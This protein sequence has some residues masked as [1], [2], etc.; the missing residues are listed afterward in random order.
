MEIDARTAE[1]QGWPFQQ[2]DLLAGMRRYFDDPTIRLVAVQPV[3][4]RAIRP[5]IG[6]IR[7]LRVLVEGQNGLKDLDLIVKEPRGTTRT[8]LAGAGRREVG[9]YQRLADH[10]PMVTPR[11]IAASQTGDWLL[12]EM[13]LSYK[14]PSRWVQAD[15]LRAIEALGELHDRFWDLDEDLNAFPWLSHPLDA[16]FD[17]H[18][19]AA[20]QAL[21]TIVHRGAPRSLAGSQQH[22]RLM[23]RMIENADLIADP[24][25]NETY[26]LLHGDYWPGN[27][28]VLDESGQV[29]FDWQ[30]T[31]VGPGI[32]DLLTF[33]VK[34]A[35]WMEESA[36]DRM[37]LITLYRRQMLER[38]G[39]AWTEDRWDLL[40]DHALM[41]RFV[42]EWVDL[43]AVTPDA[44]LETQAGLLDR[45]WL[46]PVTRAVDKRL[47]G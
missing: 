40:W 41:W 46:D 42:Q 3:T 8:G 22:M 31:A 4:I 7:G 19:A 18:I 23:A 36:P 45:L 15:Y 34:T 37:T 35:W 47:I 13:F 24:L 43:L 10:L 16:D 28:A 6:R 29:V 11:L 30:L 21:Q 5:S 32:L 2:A 39:I 33:V 26:T 20:A 44:L 25:R 38:T 17:V 9:V 14:D 12:L 1:Y 27:I